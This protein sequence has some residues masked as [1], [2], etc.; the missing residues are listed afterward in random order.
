MFDAH[1]RNVLSTTITT[2]E[3]VDENIS[4]ISQNSEEKEEDLISSIFEFLE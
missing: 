4:E 1:F 2:L 3:I